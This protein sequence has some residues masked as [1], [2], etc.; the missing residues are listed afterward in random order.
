[1]QLN[2]RLQTLLALC[3]HTKVQKHGQ[4]FVIQFLA[5]E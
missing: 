2:L 4:R 5:Q 1:M 3:M